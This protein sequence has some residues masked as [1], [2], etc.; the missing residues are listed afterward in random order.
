MTII[1]QIDHSLQNN[2]YG[3][4]DTAAL[5]MQRD[6]LRLATDLIREIKGLRSDLR[7]HANFGIK[8]WLQ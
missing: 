1:E 8:C 6:Q 4:I 3:P 5:K 2:Q 7:D